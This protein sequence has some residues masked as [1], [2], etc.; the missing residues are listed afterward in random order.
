MARIPVPVTFHSEVPVPFCPSCGKS[1][2]STWTFCV[3]CGTKAQSAP[4]TSN[5]N[6][7]HTSGTLPDT[8][9]SARAA[10]TSGGYA[11]LIMGPAL[12]YVGGWKV[13][14]A[15]YTPS[16]WH[17]GHFLGNPTYAVALGDTGA[18]IRVNGLFYGAEFIPRF[19]DVPF[20]SIVLSIIAWGLIF[21]GLGAAASASR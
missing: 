20:I 7:R 19:F 12:L 14:W 15:G 21:A 1:V 6:T 17:L 5:P 10:S 16:G 18:A 13:M 4:S 3:G 11:G 8:N 9:L 2:E